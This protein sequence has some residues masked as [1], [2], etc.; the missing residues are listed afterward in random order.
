MP[1]VVSGEVVSWTDGAVMLDYDERLYTAVLKIKVRT[2]WK[3]SAQVKDGFIY[4]TRPRGGELVNPDGTPF[5]NPGA[6]SAVTSLA[7]LRTAVPVGTRVL[8]VGDAGDGVFQYEQPPQIRTLVPHAGYPDGA[9]LLRPHAF[10]LLLEQNDGT[11]VSGSIEEGPWDALNA[12]AR[13]SSVEPFTEL[14]TQ[15]RKHYS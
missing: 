11:V 10:G 1:T 6:K 9:K 5:R 14:T 7:E 15:L 3:G 8:F 4:V 2:A 12:A 13:R